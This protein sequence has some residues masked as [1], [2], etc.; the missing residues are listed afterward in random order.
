[1]YYELGEY[2]QAIE[3]YQQ[4]LAIGVEAVNLWHKGLVFLRLGNAYAL[5]EKY[6]QAIEA[7]QQSL[8]I[9]QEIPDRA[10]VGKALNN[11]GGVYRQLGDHDKA[12]KHLEKGL[13]I[14]RELQDPL[15]ERNALL[16]LAYTYSALEN[17]TKALEYFQQNLPIIQQ[18]QDL[19]LEAETLLNIGVSASFVNDNEKAIEYFQQSLAISQK[20]Q[21]RELE[22]LALTSSGL[23]HAALG[24]VEKAIELH[25][26]SLEVARSIPDRLTEGQALGNLAFAYRALER[27][28][29]ALAYRSQSLEIFR[30]LKAY[31]DEGIALRDLGDFYSFVGNWEKA[32]DYYQE[33]LTLA[34]N[35]NDRFGKYD[36]LLGLGYTYFQLRDFDTA[37][38]YYQQALTLATNIQHPSGGEGAIHGLGH[39]SLAQGE[40]QEAIRYYQQALQMNPDNNDETLAGLG[41]AYFAD[42]DYKQA[43]VYYQQVLEI[44]RQ[45]QY[46]Q[47]E[48]VTLNNLG[49]VL[50][51]SGDYPTAE[52]TLYEAIKVGESLRVSLGTRD[53]DKVSFFDQLRRSYNTLQKVLIAQNKTLAALEIAEQGRARN[54]VELITRQLSTQ[55]ATPT[56]NFLSIQQIQQVAKAHKATLVEYSIITESLPGFSGFVDFYSEIFIWVIQPTGEI[57]FHRVDLKPFIEKY[58]TILVLNEL[59]AN[60]RQSIGV[61]GRGEEADRASI[62]IVPRDYLLGDLV[63]LKDDAENGFKEPWQVVAYDAA[64]GVLTL[65]HP[66]FDQGATITRPKS[67]VFEIVESYQRTHEQ[68]QAL[69]QLLI[70]P[71]K[72]FLPTNPNDR[73]IFIPHN[74]LFLVPF[75]ALQDASGNYLIDKHTILTAPSIQVLDLTYQ[76]DRNHEDSKTKNDWLPALIVGNPTMPK[77]ATQLGKEPEQLSNLSGAEHEAIAI[78]QLLQTKAIT[79]KDATKAKI[80]QQMPNSQLIHLATHG[81]LDDFQGQ[82][83]PGAIALAPNGTGEHNDGLLTANEILAMKLKAELVV[84]SACDTGRGTIT[85]DGVIGL[86]RSLLTAGVSSLV[87]SLWSV[88]DAP[89]AELMTQFYQQLQQNPD[90]AQALRQAMLKTKEKHPNPRDW[91][92]FT[93]IGEAE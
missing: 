68:L 13:A 8:A 88:P 48:W 66:T 29:E 30:E 71:I 77:I 21:Y 64:N 70:E 6:D 81:L 79:G 80:V 27:I 51:Q 78:S 67:D 92:A 76:Q 36:A 45:E 23:S 84:L 91:A 49:A 18:L 22:A 89:T 31:K 41:N 33:G 86:S 38:D 5:L 39:I 50:Y 90:K 61:R 75:A 57:S 17:Y 11:L 34:Q 19:E 24:N 20:H 42:G 3:Y 4:G 63:R 73:L 40:L 52:T 37:E 46:R 65:T 7:Y 2:D 47:G 25:Q 26:Q 82:G 62:A 59:I 54:F 87:V 60:S 15:E 85:G 43:I 44:A 32:R 93:L 16:G 55:T 72:Q 1:M 35:I 12:I 14:A 74:E 53:T 83:I 9:Y 28:E 10:G 69:H 56:I 58:D